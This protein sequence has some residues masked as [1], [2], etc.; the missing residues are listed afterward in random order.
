M[1]SIDPRLRV[2]APEGHPR[3]GSPSSEQSTEIESHLTE[4][5]WQTRETLDVSDTVQ[6]SQDESKNF[7]YPEPP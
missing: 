3:A 1:E 6:E 2:T 7:E 4:E 5:D